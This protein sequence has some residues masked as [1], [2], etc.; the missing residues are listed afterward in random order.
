MYTI[1]ME[2]HSWKSED[3]SSSNDVSVL[4]AKLFCFSRVTASKR[5]HLYISLYEQTTL[6]HVTSGYPYI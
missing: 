1:I 6:V 5:C 4:R 3:Q 2:F